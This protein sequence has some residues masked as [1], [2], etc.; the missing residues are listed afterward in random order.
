MVGWRK[1]KKGGSMLDKLI[2]YLKNLPKEEQEKLMQALQEEQTTKQDNEVAEE[3]TTQEKQEAEQVEEST[4]QTQEQ[5]DEN[6]TSE[7]VQEEQTKEQEVENVEEKQEEQIDNEQVEETEQQEQP[8]QDTEESTEQISTDNP[9]AF[10]ELLETKIELALVKA[11]IREDRIEA[12][13]RLFKTEIHGLEDLDKIK[14]II[15]E[16]PEWQKLKKEHGKG[17][18][19]AIKENGTSLTEEEKKLKSMGIDPKN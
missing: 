19:I 10:Q 7:Q 16:F 18:G 5:T 15:K 2:K 11:G 8:V 9:P 6:T 12:A 13:K 1:E 4:E 17:F 3:S 14:D